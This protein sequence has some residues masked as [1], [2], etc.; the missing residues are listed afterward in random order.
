PRPQ[1][2]VLLERDSQRVRPDS[3][4]ACVTHPR[5]LLER[6]ARDVE[7]HREEIA[8]QAPHYAGAHRRRIDVLRVAVDL[9]FAQREIRALNQPVPPAASSTSTS[10]TCNALAA[11]LSWRTLFHMVLL[12]G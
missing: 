5:H 2:F 7:I 4:H 8:L 12:S 3:P 1:R 10:N 9:D 11:R 6:L